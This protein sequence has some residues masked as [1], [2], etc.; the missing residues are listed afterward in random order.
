MRKAN[1][2]AGTV[3]VLIGVFF[4]WSS[5]KL[6]MGAINA[7]EAGFVSFWEGI[8]L[9]LAG[10]ALI[11]TSARADLRERVKW[12]GGEARRMILYLAATLV[13]YIFLSEIL[14]YITTT[15]IF[16][17][18]ASMA[19]RRNSVRVAFMYAAAFA[20][21]MYVVFDLLLRAPLPRSPFGL[22]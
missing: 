4:V 20:A 14:G 7:P 6:P 3:V 10:G 21:G 2:V 16:F 8:M 22:P 18:M 19:W 5:R 12:P 1:I 13:G 15:F 9:A 17:W 11:F